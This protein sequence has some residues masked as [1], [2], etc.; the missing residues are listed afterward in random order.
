[1]DFVF[2]LAAALMFAGVVGM[3]LGCDKLLGGRA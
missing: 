3:A 2:L 1:M